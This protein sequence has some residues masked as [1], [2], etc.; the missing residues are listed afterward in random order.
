ME[1]AVHKHIMHCKYPPTVAE[2]TDILGKLHTQAQ[3]TY[4]LVK[5]FDPAASGDEYQRI[6][7]ITARFAADP[8][9]ERYL[10]L[11]GPEIRSLT[12]N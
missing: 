7:D 4:H 12:D 11:T 10:P 8:R 6:M 9:T 2:I 1:Y 5:Q 3:A